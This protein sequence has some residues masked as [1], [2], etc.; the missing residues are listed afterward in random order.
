MSRDPEEIFEDP[1]EL[2]AEGVP[3]VDFWEDDLDQL[4]EAFP[5]A[6]LL[7]IGAGVRVAGGW[8][9][10]LAWELLDSGVCLPKALKRVFPFIPAMQT[11][12]CG[13]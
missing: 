5:M 1:E 4:G 10:R 8:S 3:A 11:H 9:V 6:L 12:E 7:A 13:E 2:W